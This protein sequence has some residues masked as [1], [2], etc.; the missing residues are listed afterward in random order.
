MASNYTQNIGTHML[1]GIDLKS[2]GVTVDKSTGF[3][4]MPKRKEILEMDWPDRHGLV[5]DLVEFKTSAR[6]LKL[7]LHVI[8]SN[9]M[10]LRFNLQ[11]LYTELMRPG[12]Q[13]LKM[14]GMNVINLVYLKD[15]IYVDRQTKNNANKSYAKVE[16][17]L[18]EPYPITLQY[19]TDQ[20]A[21]SQVSLQIFCSKPVTVNWG[22]RTFAYL[23]GSGTVTKN[24]SQTGFYCIVVYGEVDSVT[25]VSTNASEIIP[26]EF[27]ESFN[28]NTIMTDDIIMNDDIIFN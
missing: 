25:S 7:N 3:L 16:V 13:Y 21:L 22:D 23:A 20:T 19:I 8:G 4:N 1:N 17:S 9:L 28:D 18:I 11:K 14:G 26:Y 27:A 10:N 15:E 6:H 5:A 24:Y 12:H 2:I